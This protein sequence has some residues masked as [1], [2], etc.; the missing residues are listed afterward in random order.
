MPVRSLQQ[1]KPQDLYL[2]GTGEL[3]SCRHEHSL[4]KSDGQSTLSLTIRECPIPSEATHR[5]PLI[6][7]AASLARKIA[8]EA[9]AEQINLFGK[10]MSGE[11]PVRKN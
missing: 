1:M 11:S 2:L 8:K 5:E 4:S 9:E 7:E 6:A 3:S 10:K